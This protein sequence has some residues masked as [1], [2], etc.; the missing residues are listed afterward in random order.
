MNHPD[1]RRRNPD[2][3]QRLSSE[4]L[5]RELEAVIDRIRSSVN[6]RSPFGTSSGGTGPKEDPIMT[7]PTDKD[8]ATEEPD[9]CWE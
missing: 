7:Y 1:R 9:V 4:Q 2:E 3:Q 6:G 5:R 8:A